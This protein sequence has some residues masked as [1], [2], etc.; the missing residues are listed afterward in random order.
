MSGMID[1]Y[2]DPKDKKE[3]IAHWEFNYKSALKEGSHE[4]GKKIV[5][6]LMEAIISRKSDPIKAEMDKLTAFYEE[7]RI[8]KVNNTFVYANADTT[9]IANRIGVHLP[10]DIQMGRTKN[11][12]HARSVGT[13]E[14]RR[15]ETNVEVEM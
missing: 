7:N 1:N 9:Q 4:E 13:S 2:I 12:S 6:D 14:E 3:A 11:E 5:T 10:V 15:Q 8:N